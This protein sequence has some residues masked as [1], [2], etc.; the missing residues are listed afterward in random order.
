M[1]EFVIQVA[2]ETSNNWIP[3]EDK[4]NKKSAQLDKHIA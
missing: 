1:R 4:P 2:Q 3:E